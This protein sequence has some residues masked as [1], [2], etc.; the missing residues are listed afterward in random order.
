MQI[1]IHCETM[2]YELSFKMNIKHLA[3]PYHA[4]I[5]YL[6]LNDMDEQIHEPFAAITYEEIIWEK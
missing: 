1:N 6:L 2:S 3:P 5:C 4:Q